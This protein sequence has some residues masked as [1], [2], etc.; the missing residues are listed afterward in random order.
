MSWREIRT[1]RA[2]PELRAENEASRAKLALAANVNRL[3]REHSLSQSALARK[4]GTRQPHI[5]E[6]ER[7]AANPRLDT[8][9]K[10]AAA[11]GRT[12]AELYAER[13]AVESTE[14]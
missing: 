11:L 4:S 12:V 10:L 6:I 2:R 13:V 5:S 7:G 14:T 9:A 3:R 1:L 8:V